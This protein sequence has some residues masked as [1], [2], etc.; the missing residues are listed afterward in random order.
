VLPSSSKWREFKEAFRLL[1][2]RNPRSEI[3]WRYFIGISWFFL[4]NPL[5]SPGL[6]FTSKNLIFV[7]LS[8]PR[9]ITRDEIRGN[10]SSDFA[11]TQIKEKNMPISSRK[12]TDD[13]AQLEY[14][15]RIA[16]LQ[17]ML[18]AVKKTV[19]IEIAPGDLTL[20]IRSN[21]RLCFAK[22]VETLYNV[23]WQSYNQ[24]L[25]SNIFSWTPQYQL[26]GSNLFM[27]D[28]TVQVVTNTPTIGLGQTC[29]LDDLGIL[30]PAFDG[31]PETSLTM[32]NDGGSI[33]P[34]VM[35]L[36]TGI[37]GSQGSA[38][39][40]VTENPVVQGI[41]SLT[42]MESVLVWFE[43]EIETSTMFLAA[44]NNS[45]EIDLTNVDWATRVYEGQK[46]SIPGQ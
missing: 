30:G 14:T 23:V 42:P 13:F 35:Q 27:A 37:D 21:Y 34:G 12:V 38:P 43:Q 1:Q 28:L 24:Y 26:F 4:Y 15:E 11:L 39:I 29:I 17:R 7:L 36:S 25:S 18:D 3:E 44:R 22:K 40:Y 41:E 8:C 33:Y 46:W 20:L 45:V 32:I 2:I 6:P 9:V 5:E 31:G 10:G 16:T 19:K